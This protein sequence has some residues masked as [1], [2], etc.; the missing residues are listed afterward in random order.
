MKKERL[1]GL[2]QILRNLESHGIRLEKVKPWKK[3]G[4]FHEES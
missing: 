3:A 4:V 1:P 2:P